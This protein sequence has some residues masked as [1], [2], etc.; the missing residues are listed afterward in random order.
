[1][2]KKKKKEWSKR[3]FNMSKEKCLLLPLRWWRPAGCAWQR[4]KIWQW[5]LQMRSTASAKEPL[6]K[7]CLRCQ[8]RAGE[9]HTVKFGD[10]LPI[11]WLGA[12]GGRDLWLQKDMTNNNQQTF[13]Q[14]CL[15]EHWHIALFLLKGALFT[16]PQTKQ[17]AACSMCSLLWFS[18]VCITF[19]TAVFK[20]LCVQ[21]IKLGVCSGPLACAKCE[22]KKTAMKKGY[23][24]AAA[25]VVVW[26]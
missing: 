22:G 17:S 2:E 10:P 12:V 13:A 24:S 11:C 6:C 15:N 7:H 9:I 4:R 25:A 23:Y 21:L 5:K 18:R 14:G 26:V 1:M 20:H 3:I 16:G 19:F 8:F